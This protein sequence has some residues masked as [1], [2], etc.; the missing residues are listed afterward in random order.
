[1]SKVG[2][3]ISINV[4]KLDKTKF[5]KGAKGTYVDLTTFVELDEVDKYGQSGFVK[6][7]A[8]KGVEMPILGNV[9]IFWRDDSPQSAPAPSQQPAQ[10]GGGFD[11]F[12]EP[13][14]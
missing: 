14:F 1:M 2:I 5:H 13:P 7:T 3:S 11:D 10:Q 9:K 8:D 4:E 6:Q 12:D